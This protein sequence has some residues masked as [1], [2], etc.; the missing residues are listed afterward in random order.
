[1][2]SALLALALLP[3]AM[4]LSAGTAR[5]ELWTDDALTRET[6]VCALG[7]TVRLQA[8]TRSCMVCHDGTSGTGVDTQRPDAAPS[9]LSAMHRSHPVDVDYAVAQ[10]RKPSLL[11]PAAA[12]P[13][14]LVLPGGLVTCVTCHDGASR[15]PAHAAVTASRSRLCTSCH[16]L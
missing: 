10:I 11:H 16:D 3:G 4:L 5:S 7:R 14:S 1:M 8:T 15:E 9:T 6:S 13:P 12:L 2:R